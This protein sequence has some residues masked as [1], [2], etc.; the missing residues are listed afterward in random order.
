M[1]N[2]HGSSRD[3]G[4]QEIWQVFGVAGPSENQG[5]KTANVCTTTRLPCM[6]LSGNGIWSAQRHCPRREYEAAH[7][8][9]ARCG[10]SGTRRLMVLDDQEQSAHLDNGSAHFL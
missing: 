3:D 2:T 1:S 7:I 10:L 9:R 5:L 8:H 6:V 4:P